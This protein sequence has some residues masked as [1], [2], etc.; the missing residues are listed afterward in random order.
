ME[1][2]FPALAGSLALLA[3]RLRSRRGSPVVLLIAIA[4]LAGAGVMV[5][6]LAIVSPQSILKS[7]SAGPLGTISDLISDLAE[8]APK[9]KQELVVRLLGIVSFVIGLGVCSLYIIPMY[10]SQ[11]LSGFNAMAE[12][13]RRDMEDSDEVPGT[14]APVA[15]DSPAASA[16]A[17]PVSPEAE[18]Q[19]ARGLV[20][21]A[22]K[23]WQAGRR[24]QSVAAAKEALTLFQTHLGADHAETKRV[25]QMVASAEAQAART[26]AP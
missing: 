9:G 5:G 24:T 16:A 26:A 1:G 19:R 13:N 22:Q 17:T 20:A 21:D 15:E 2:T 14:V 12:Q 4:I 11:S 7:R 8:R 18:L 10:Q 3:L 6:L 25:A 23:A